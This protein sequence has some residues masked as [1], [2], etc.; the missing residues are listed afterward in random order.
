MPPSLEN[1]NP[2]PKDRQIKIVSNIKDT[3][4]PKSIHFVWLG[5]PMPEKYLE[6]IL[7]L[8][9]SAKQSGFQLNLWM[10]DSSQ[11]KI[12]KTMLK[13]GLEQDLSSLGI[14]VRNINELK[15]PMKSDPFYLSN[16]NNQQ[17][18]KKYNDFWQYVD[19]ERIG[20]KNYGSASDLLRYEILR[21]EGGYYF[22][23]DTLFPAL[24]FD[25]KTQK[26]KEPQD[27]D[28]VGRPNFVA[29][30]MEAYSKYEDA[31][32]RYS[33]TASRLPTLTNDNPSHGILI[34]GVSATVN[35]ENDEL[36]RQELFVDAMGNDIIAASP[37]HK[38]MQEAINLSIQNYQ[39]LDS[40][41]VNPI[42]PKLF[43][44]LV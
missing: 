12:R 18:K 40:Q 37:N 25:P 15:E 32:K 9:A 20:L 44:P 39:K 24:R 31:K 42:D 28:F 19:R 29:N 27:S 17:S 38:V 26:P 7:S 11:K 2:I 22:D 3:S 35:G 6:N 16:N 34:G 13:M 36:S 33:E 14:E 21:Q 43:N 1:E 4:I 10:D 41:R 5:G 30:Y 23:T 8:A